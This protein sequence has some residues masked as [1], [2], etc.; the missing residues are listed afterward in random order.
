M[1]NKVSLVFEDG[2]Y[3]VYI[4][5][6]VVSVD[7]DIDNSFIKFKQTIKNNTI[8]NSIS[9]ESREQELKKLNCKNLK[10]DS[11]YKTATLGSMKYF[12]NTEKVFYIKDGEMLQLIGG[13]E[14]FFFVTNLIIKGEINNC[15]ELLDLFK[16]ITGA[17]AKYRVSEST[18][19]VSSAKFSYGSVEYNFSSKKINKGTALEKSTFSEF[20]N[21]ILN[22]LS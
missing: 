9:W 7:D 10:I 17:K 3:K 22:I 15:E 6:S 13:Y 21:Y 4:N 18:I 19:F 16:A 12:Y 1:N 11:N 2:K 14:L 8:N 20:K 5:E